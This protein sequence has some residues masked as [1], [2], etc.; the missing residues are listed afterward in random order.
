MSQ[1]NRWAVYQNTILWS[2]LNESTSTYH[3]RL[4]NNVGRAIALSPGAPQGPNGCLPKVKDIPP[5][6]TFSRWARK[7][8][9]L[10][11]AKSTLVELEANPDCEQDNDEPKKNHGVVGESY[12]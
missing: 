11:D 12:Q 6:V 2:S 4:M 10:L 9:C 1:T 7:I 8:R 3:H 5:K